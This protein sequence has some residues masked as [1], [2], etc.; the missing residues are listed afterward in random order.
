VVTRDTWPRE[1]HRRSPVRM[2]GHMPGR[3]TGWP[4]QAFDLLLELDGDP[5]VEVRKGLRRD[6][7]RMIRQPMIALLQ[8]VADAD[9]AYEDFSVWSFRT[10]VWFWQHQGAVV[11]IAPRVDISLTF[12]LDGL[13]VKGAWWYPLLGQ[14]E[15]FRVA[16]AATPSGQKLSRIVATLSR[17]GL[18]IGGDVMRRQPRGYPSDHP[19]AELLRH[20]SLVATDR[21]GCADW[22]HTREPVDRVLAA[23]AR[24]RPMLTW[25]AEHVAT[26][27]FMGR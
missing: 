17:Q 16:V 1:N 3:F 8:D 23:F 11:R 24:L 25:F 14:I 15:R 20:R 6:R 21:L 4:E 26:D 22:L 5:S 10:L 9:A 19:R 18:E 7:E 13:Q 12:D 2:T 27:T